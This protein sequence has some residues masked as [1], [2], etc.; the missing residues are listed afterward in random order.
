MRRSKKL[1]QRDET[2]S[3]TESQSR[4]LEEDALF[5]NAAAEYRAVMAEIDSKREIKREL[6][7]RP[8]KRLSGVDMVKLGNE[9]DG[10]SEKKLKAE[11]LEELRKVF[12]ERNGEILR[13][14]IDDADVESF[15][16]GGE[17]SSMNGVK[18]RRSIELLR[19]DDKI[20]LL[21]RRYRS[22]FFSFF[23]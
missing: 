1:N 3:P 15:E 14:F 6:V 13:W 11:R 4:A 18:R 8:W 23:F 16:D 12:V 7:G 5:R 21:A 22:Y 9:T 2:L 10:F 17:K 20:K 19:D